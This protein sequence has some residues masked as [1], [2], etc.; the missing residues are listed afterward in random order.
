MTFTG[1][2]QIDLSS[3]EF[4]YLRRTRSDNPP[5]SLPVSFPRPFPAPPVVMLG[6]VGFYG[7]GDPFRFR[8][9]ASQISEAG[10]EIRLYTNR[11]WID[12]LE[13]SWLATDA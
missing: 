10:F 9:E 12:T 11:N 13:I 4:D 5:V 8:M 2:L 7:G 6:L 1:S 3:R